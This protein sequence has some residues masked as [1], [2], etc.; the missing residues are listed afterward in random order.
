MAHYQITCISPRVY[1]QLLIVLAL[2]PSCRRCLPFQSRDRHRAPPHSY[3]RDRVRGPHERQPT[4][5]HAIFVTAFPIYSI[6]CLSSIVVR[7]Y[8]ASPTVLSDLN[9]LLVLDT[10][11][12]AYAEVVTRLVNAAPS[13][14]N[15]DDKRR[16]CLYRS[17]NA[18]Y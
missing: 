9:A 1:N 17:Y 2:L 10:E 3:R 5:L 4:M 6:I 16:V 15:F 8:L 14:Q 11:V 7:T 12:P 13:F 18:I